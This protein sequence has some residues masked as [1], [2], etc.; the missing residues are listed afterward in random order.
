MFGLR[1]V[2]F[3]SLLAGV[4]CSLHFV[5][6]TLSRQP[7]FTGQSWLPL[8]FSFEWPSVAYALDILGWD[9]FFA[10]SALFAAPVFLI[11]GRSVRRPPP[12]RGQTSRYHPRTRC[13]NATRLRANTLRDPRVRV[14]TARVTEG[15]SP[16]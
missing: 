4:T 12:P 7:E 2:I 8:V 15:P 6:L 9:V 11:L 16:S 3:M 10:L 1:S 5:I 14:D 13:E